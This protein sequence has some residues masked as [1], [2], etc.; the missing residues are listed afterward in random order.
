[1]RGKKTYLVLFFVV[2]ALVLK[3]QDIPI[4]EKFQDVPLLEVIK[5]LEQKYPVHFFFDPASIEGILVTAEFQ[6]TPLESC[7][8]LHPE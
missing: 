2:Y 5:A 3:S 6:Q 1:M 7:L 8:E 4:S